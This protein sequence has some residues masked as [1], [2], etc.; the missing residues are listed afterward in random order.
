MARR[1]G[2][3]ELARRLCL[4]NAVL[5]EG[6][7]EAK[8]LVGRVMAGHPEYRPQA[9]AVLAALEAA[10]AAVN[11]LTSDEQRAALE[12]EA[13]DL[14]QAPVRERRTGLRELANV[15]G[16]V[17]LRFAPN[18]NGPLSLGHSRGVSLLAEYW[19]MYG[20]RGGAKLIL[21][22]DDTDP[23]VKPPLWDKVRGWNGYNMVRED[24]VW[25]TGREPSKE[26]V[27]SDRIAMYQKAARDLIAVGGA[28]VCSCDAALFRQL[29]AAGQACPHRE[30]EPDANQAAFADMVEGRTAKG[31]AVLRV[32]TD[33]H[34]PDP[35]L[36]DWT[37]FRVVAEDAIHPREREGEIPRHRAWPLLDFESAVEDHLQGVTH[38][39][40]GKD[41]MD[42][43]RKQGYLYQAM[44]WKYPETLYWGRVRLHGFGRFSTS[45][46]RRAIERGDFPG[47]DD[48]RLPTLSALRRRGYAAEALRSFW[49]GLGL[50]E[51]DIAVSMANLD[52]VD[53]K[54]RDDV[55][56]RYFFVPDAREVTVMGLGSEVAHV[57]LH[58]SH[59]DRGTRTLTP[60]D[61]VWIPAAERHPAVRLKDLGN[62]VFAG[63]SGIFA[64]RQMDRS[65]PIIQWLPKEEARPFSVLRPEPVPEEADVGDDEAD[66]PA[67]IK[68]PPLTR[69]EGLVEPAALAEVGKVV[70]FERFGFVRLE[71]EAVGLW[72]HG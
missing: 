41:L 34:H 55:T 44:G 64:G 2:L 23:Q 39:I 13:P 47:W 3:A 72:L 24:F 17:V 8:G 45:M 18:P 53:Q 67:E 46:M 69:I 54:L 58:P 42:S 30:T 6:R 63:G 19:R 27:A 32:K 9:A 35:A 28:Y 7:A 68:V 48:P 57:P 1:V 65:L 5:H 14:V 21:R 52:A 12:A 66:G 43:T 20:Q 11:A 37:A 16:E 70:Q 61:A 29:K 31:S 59:A 50:T 33:I 38:V 56:S 36:R 71:S 49:V 25:L 4:Q 15:T 26:V 40:R 60:H 22:F 62:V 10:A 51:K